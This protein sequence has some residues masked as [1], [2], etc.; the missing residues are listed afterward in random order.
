M[1]TTIPTRYAWAVYARFGNK[2]AGCMGWYQSRSSAEECKWRNRR[3]ASVIK[4][5]RVSAE[6]FEQLKP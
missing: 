3:V 6:E 2:P 1:K 5:E 4:R